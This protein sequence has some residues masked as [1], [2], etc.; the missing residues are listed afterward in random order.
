MIVLPVNPPLQPLKADSHD[1]ENPSFWPAGLAH[2][3]D[4]GAPP[5]SADV[6]RTSGVTTGFGS[7]KGAFSR[8]GSL[9]RSLVAG[10][11]AAAGPRVTSLP[12]R[13]HLLVSLYV[14]MSRQ[15][16]PSGDTLQRRISI[17]LRRPPHPSCESRFTTSTASLRRA[18]TCIVIL[19]RGKWA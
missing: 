16:G 9:R 17:R 10:Y 12:P 2:V 4:F 15:D 14:W 5:L 11:C 3:T 19:Q 18:G 13:C 8:S 7:R 6:G 1:G